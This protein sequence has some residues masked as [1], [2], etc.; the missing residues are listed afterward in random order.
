LSGRLEGDASEVDVTAS[1]ATRLGDDHPLVIEL[2]RRVALEDVQVLDEY[3]KGEL[4]PEKAAIIY[5]KV[6]DEFHTP[7]E[8]YK[9]LQAWAEVNG[10]D[11]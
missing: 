8:Y 1:L 6:P 5:T 3:I 4:G 11:V 9:E 7:L 2:R 10:L